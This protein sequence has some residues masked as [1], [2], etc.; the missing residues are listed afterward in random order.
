MLGEIPEGAVARS[1]AHTSVFVASA[2]AR[3]SVWRGLPR[4]QFL[5]GVC[6]LLGWTML[7]GCTAPAIRN[8]SP[9]DEEL[10]SN[11][12]LVGE[13]A[14]PFGM[15]IQ[16]VEGIALVNGLPGT[17]AIAPP[18]RN[19]TRCCAICKRAACPSRRA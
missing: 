15:V 18:R 2:M 17:G 14:V 5:A 12:H 6:G 13:Y 11:T 16:K 3:R 19:A 8:Q 10:E 7:H 9:E 1:F 4:R